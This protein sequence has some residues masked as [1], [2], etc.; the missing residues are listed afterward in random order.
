MELVDEEGFYAAYVTKLQA[1]DK[2]KYYYNVTK[3]DGTVTLIDDPYRF[4]STIDD[5]VLRK[6]NAGICYDIYNYLGAHVKTIDG[7]KGTA[8]AVFAPNAI[9][10]SVIGDFNG[11]DGRIHQMRRLSDSGVFEIFIPGVKP[12]DAYKYEIKFKGSAIAIKSDPYGFMSKLR[13][14]NDSV[15]ADMKSFDFTDNCQ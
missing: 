10:V 14:G 1:F 3:E 4:K 11:W 9:R 15:V 5:N 8:F 13:P 12:Y 6:F 2:I 7:V